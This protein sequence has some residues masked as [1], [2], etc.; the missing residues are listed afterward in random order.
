MQKT[1]SL[2]RVIRRRAGRGIDNSQ[3][4][5]ITD[6]VELAVAFCDLS[7]R[8][9]IQYGLPRVSSL[10]DLCVREYIL[11][12]KLRRSHV[13]YTDANLSVIFDI[14][15]SVHRM[16]QESNHYFN[17]MKM[18]YWACLRCGKKYTD[19]IQFRP[20]ICRGCNKKHQQFRY[21]EV[22]LE[23]PGLTGHVDLIIKNNSMDKPR[24]GDIKSIRKEDFVSLIRP[25]PEHIY[26]ITGYIYMLS[27]LRS[28]NRI[29]L[30]ID[31]TLGY[32]IYISKEHPGKNNFPIKIFPVSPE[33]VYCDDIK[34]KIFSYLNYYDYKTRTVRGLPAPVD[35]CSS[36]NWNVFRSRQCPVKKECLMYA[37]KYEG[38]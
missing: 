19:E 35:E 13:R 37:E 20:I 33:S 9:E 1:S 30:D 6:P 2:S 34:K 28:K 8:R 15:H 12:H 24:V 5:G 14:G 11:G 25:F 32:V 3:T 31:D 22:E 16:I 10:Y 29:G 4:S 36:G 26:Q 7:V 18:G 27:E 21:I 17:N 23:L 38:L